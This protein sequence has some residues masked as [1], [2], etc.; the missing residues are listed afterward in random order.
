MS[1]KFTLFKIYL[2]HSFVGVYN[3]TYEKAYRLSL[4]E[5]D[6]PQLYDHLVRVN[7][8][9]DQRL[10]L[11]MTFMVQMITQV[12]SIISILVYLLFINWLI[13]LILFFGSI[14]FTLLQVKVF[15]E[16]YLL[17]RQQTTPGRKVAYLSHLMTARSPARELRLYGL[18]DYIKKEWNKINANLISDRLKL[19]RKESS[20]EIVGSSGNT[21]TFAVTL[22]IIIA[23]LMRGALSVGQ[24]AAFLRAVI[25]FQQD[26]TNFMYNIAI[27]QA[28]LR[29]IEDFFVYLDLQ[30]EQ[31]KGIPL[32]SNEGIKKGIHFK[33][34]EFAYPEMKDLVIKGVNLEIKPGEKVAL[35]GDNGSGKS[36]IIKLLLG[37]HQPS[38]GEVHIDGVNISEIDLND[39]WR[40]T[41]T[42]FQDF[43][44]FQLLNVRENIAIGQMQDMN[45]M[46]KIQQATLLSGA[47]EMIQNLPNKYETMLGKEFGGHELSQGQWQRIAVSR[48]YMR[49][50]DI[51]ILDEPTASLDAKAEYNIYRQ[52][53][54][55]AK[56]KTVVFISHR[57]GVARLA[58][59][60]IVLKE[61]KIIEQGTHAELMKKEGYYANMYQLQ[62]QWYK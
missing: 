14:V 61:G 58:D 50:A 40:R 26:L 27:I 17:D 18:Q 42:V 46:D 10:F 44:K 31:R 38:N 59:R 60:V 36:T 47:D 4:A 6:R 11:T 39:W 30:D 16:R 33:D 5:F 62:A 34:V 49:D 1:E 57:L 55:I 20:I 52:F 7:Q 56:N 35:L 43:Q 8:G 54:Q 9:M 37:L 53:E 15:K 3:D 13:P 45:D 23:L 22:M 21:L 51:L 19:T 12:S 2:I 41:T 48:A 25:S 32:N 29:Y 28:D 24:Y